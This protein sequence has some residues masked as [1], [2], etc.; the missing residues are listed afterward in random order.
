MRCDQK[1]V[2]VHQGRTV[3]IKVLQFAQASHTTRHDIHSYATT[4]KVQHTRAL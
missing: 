3:D 4:T 1:Y 2:N